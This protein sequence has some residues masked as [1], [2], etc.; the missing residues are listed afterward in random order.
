ML[1]CLASTS[2]SETAEID[3]HL[4]AIQLSFVRSLLHR[5]V[6]F[7]CLSLLFCVGSMNTPK[8]FHIIAQGA[9]TLGPWVYDHPTARN[10]ERGSTQQWLIPNIP[11]INRNTIFFAQPPKLILK[12]LLAMM[13]FLICDVCFDLLHVRGA[14]GKRTIA[15]PP[16]KRG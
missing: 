8:A 14:D 12:R 9:S 15:I 2:R 6:I 4:D 16:M 10:P 3:M 11:F 5:I 1:A 13:L 7:A